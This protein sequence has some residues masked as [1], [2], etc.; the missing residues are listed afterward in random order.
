[1]EHSFNIELAQ[2]YGILEAILLK[3]IYFWVKKNKANDKNYHDGFYWTYNSNKA[4]TEL[5]P[6]ASEKKIRSALSKLEKEGLI[7]V[8]N[9]NKIAYDRTKWY[10]LTEEGGK[11]L[12]VDISHF[13]KRAN[14][15]DKKANGNDQKGEPIPDIN[16]DINT[17]INKERKK[18][19]QK[20]SS[21]DEIINSMVTDE[22]LKENIYEFVKMR[23][24]IKKPM[25]DRALKLLI[26]KLYKLSNNI[27][28][29]LKILDKSIVNNWSDIYPL[30]KDS[31][32]KPKQNFK[33]REYTE[34]ELDYFNQLGV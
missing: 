13:T 22:R 32:P 17:D 9:H 1:M 33:G 10:T 34:E 23:K 4:F 5:F 20:N 11:A 31:L 25:T 24:I 21:Y 2:K 6:Y 16:T 29:Q 8:G 3:N 26:N 15:F 19:E 12:N 28:E 7:K 18:E 30:K 14:G 27:E